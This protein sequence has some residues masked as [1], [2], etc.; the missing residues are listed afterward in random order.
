MGELRKMSL[1]RIAVHYDVISPYSWIGFEQILRHQRIWND[2][3]IRVDLKPTFIS[4]IIKESGNKPPGVVPNK[5]V[6]MI[7][8]IQRLAKFYKIPLNPLSDPFT[9]LFSKRLIDIT[10][11]ANDAQAFGAPTFIIRE[12]GEDDKMFFGQDRIELLC[13][14]IGKE[15]Y[16]PALTGRE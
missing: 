11:E 1:R 3:T 8:D 2:Q 9:T 7:Q 12:E 4:G 15:Y 14:E 16:G 13:S 5:S 6:Y 10:E